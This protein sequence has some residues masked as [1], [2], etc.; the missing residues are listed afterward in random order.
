MR[1]WTKA[2][3]AVGLLACAEGIAAAEPSCSS[4]DTYC[5]STANALEGN[6]NPLTGLTNS[7]LQILR[8]VLEIGS[9]NDGVYVVFDGYSGN[10]NPLDGYL[11]IDTRD[12]MKSNSL[13]GL[14]GN[15]HGDFNR[16]GNGNTPITA[17]LGLTPNLNN[18]QL[19]PI[20]IQGLGLVPNLSFLE[21]GHI[22]DLPLSVPLLIEIGHDALPA[23]IQK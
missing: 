3:V 6:G 1:A 9:R 17:L 5:I 10:V 23:I 7:P 19:Q 15:D 2:F 4:S 18:L 13:L 16:N 22:P 21:T 11:G 12:L 14:V 20:A 8:G